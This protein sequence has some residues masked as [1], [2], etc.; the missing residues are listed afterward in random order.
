LHVNGEIICLISSVLVG[1]NGNV[2]K[3]GKNSFK[4]V[5][6]SCKGVYFTGYMFANTGEVSI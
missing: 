3:L 1:G 2:H 5:I 4:K 6:K